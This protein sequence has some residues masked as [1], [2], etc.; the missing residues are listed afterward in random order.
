MYR[1][2]AYLALYNR[3]LCV[4]AERRRRS[5]SWSALL[6]SPSFWPPPSVDT[7]DCER[8]TQVS[9]VHFFLYIYIYFFHVY[10]CMMKEGWKKRRILIYTRLFY[11]FP[12]KSKRVGE[13]AY[14]NAKRRQRVN[15]KKSARN[16]VGRIAHFK[17][18]SVRRPRLH[19]QSQSQ[20]QQQPPIVTT[21]IRPRSHS[22]S[23]RPIFCP[24]V[25]LLVPWIVVQFRLPLC[26]RVHRYVFYASTIVN[27]RQTRIEIE[28][29]EKISENDMRMKMSKTIAGRTKNRHRRHRHHRRHRRHRRP[30]RR[31]PLFTS[32]LSLVIYTPSFT[33]LS[34]SFSFVHSNSF[35]EN[36]LVSFHASFK[37]FIFHRFSLHSLTFFYLYSIK[38]DHKT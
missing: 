7:L 31:R 22:R 13:F 10:L 11:I 8:R 19:P 36:N 21:A 12:D 30:C 26:L 28:I 18:N 15:S 29:F 37:S 24:R 6:Y 32:L 16:N 35:I 34:S 4:F 2:V 3:S 1:H 23:Y 14:E 25:P 20:P 33:N 5:W 17:W 9:S 27:K 38:H